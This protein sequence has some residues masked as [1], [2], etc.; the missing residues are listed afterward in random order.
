MEARQRN[1]KMKNIIAIDGPS[2]V[3]KSTAAKSAASL[4]NWNYMDTGAMYRAVTLALLRAGVSIDDR[5]GTGRV[6]ASLDYE[7][8]G[9]SYFLNGED[10]S[11][12]IRSP[13]VT[14][15]VSAVSADSG[16]R[17]AL[18]RL[19]RELGQN[20]NWV[21]DGRDIGAVVFPCAAC[22]FYLTACQDVRAQ[23]RFLE[24]QAKGMR[25]TLEEVL[26][27]QARRDHIDSTREISPL[28]KADDAIELDS[29]NLS[30]EEVVNRI[31]NTVS[32][33][34]SSRS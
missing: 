6:L 19:Q 13:E 18:V 26:A 25:T 29:S 27:D 5:G 10:V 15:S 11:E 20:G 8:R 2:G 28:R 21:I 1:I 22:K 23:R 14:K 24:L 7:Q 30:L 34:R 16:V 33:L 4:L 32:A 9:N 17:E 12:A 3:G 31:I